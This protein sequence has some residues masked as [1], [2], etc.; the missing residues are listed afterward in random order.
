MYTCVMGRV[1]GN[2]LAWDL[3]EETVTPLAT[4]GVIPPWRTHGP[5][6]N[7]D[8]AKGWSDDRTIKKPDSTIVDRWS[9]VAGRRLSGSRRIRSFQC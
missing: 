5:S 9:G 7:F 2:G 6:H 8:T 4:N 1:G 3:G